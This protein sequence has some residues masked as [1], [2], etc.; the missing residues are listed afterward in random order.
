MTLPECVS[1]EALIHLLVDGLPQRLKVQALLIRGGYDEIAANTSLV[2]KASQRPS[3][4]P[5]LVREVS[6][7]SEDLQPYRGSL[8]TERNFLNCNKKGHISR[9]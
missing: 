3:Q 9:T 8:F 4:G 2:S 7:G 6:E 5:E 1:E